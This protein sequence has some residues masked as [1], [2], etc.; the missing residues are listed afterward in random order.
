MAVKT[1]TLVSMPVRNPRTGAKSRT[2]TFYGKIDRLDP[3]RIVDWKSGDPVRF[4]KRARIG[5]QAELYA[6]AVEPVIITEVA[7]RIVERPSL[8]YCQPRRKWAVMRKGRKTALK[9]FDTEHPARTLAAMQNGYVQERV[10]GDASRSEYED[11]CYNWLLD[12]PA[13]MLDHSLPLTAPRKER[14]KRWLWDSCK[15]LLECRAYKRWMPNEAACYAYE[16]ECPY[17]PLCECVAAG[18]D[19]EW[20]I[21]EGFE[22]GNRHPELGDTFN[23]LSIVTYSSLSCRALCDTKHYWKYECGYRPKRDDAEARRI[24]SA[25]H[26]GLQVYADGGL[27]P[28]CDAVDTWADENPVLGE[29]AAWKQDEQIAKARAMVRA[30]AVK[31]PVEAIPEPQTPEPEPE[32]EPESTM[33]VG[34]EIPF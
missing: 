28:A 18:G 13:R 17:M 22:R 1:E 15:R 7:Y 11:R 34:V 29:D 19:L 4:I 8:R 16:R 32:V 24:G 27:G 21:E 9:V 5:C 25:M 26:A 33:L 12:D 10:Q 14:A 2:F 23:L 20:V 3:P 6:L 31:W 30:A